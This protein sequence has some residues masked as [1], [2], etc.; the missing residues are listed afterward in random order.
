ML[1]ISSAAKSGC[2]SKV[3]R[4]IRKIRES[5][6]IFFANAL[7]NLGIFESRR[8]WLLKLAGIQIE[9]DIAI[10][11]PI[12][13]SPRSAGNLSVGHGG[14]IN[15]GC[16]FACPDVPIT[17]G[18][19][20][21]IGSRVCFETVAHVQEPIPNQRRSAVSYPI[22]IEDQVWIGTGAIILAGVKIGY[23]AIVGAGAVVTKSVSPLTIVGGV[24]AKVIKE[25]PGSATALS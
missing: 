5:F 11:A 16:R 22:I 15:T 14:F 24:P 23:G 21:K 17:I 1:M 20:V 7:P 8:Y 25:L 12:E 2:K 13:I 19:F 6:F 10:R 18:N 9:G 4:V 3:C